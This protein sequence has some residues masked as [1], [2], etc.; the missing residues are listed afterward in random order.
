MPKNR[1][2]IAEDNFLNLKLM[3]DIL[4]SQGYVVDVC[5]N[6]E[7][8]L[9]KLSENS[10]DLLLLDLQMPKISGF[11]VLEKLKKENNPIKTVVVS[12]CAMSEEVDKAK[13]LGCIDFVTKPIRLNDFLGVV[14]QNLA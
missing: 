1:I 12:A 4:S 10:Y 9:D 11:D 3:F 7:E 13:A 5:S 14:K 2:L 6:G 8:A